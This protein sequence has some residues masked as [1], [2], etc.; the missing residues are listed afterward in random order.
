MA[1]QSIRVDAD[2]K[3]FLIRFAIGEGLAMLSVVSL[4]FAFTD[5]DP[6]VLALGIAGVAIIAGMFLVPK[7]LARS[8][9]QTDSPNFTDGAQ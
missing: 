8:Q 6:M 2:L 5:R 4:W 1:D 7:I 3:R 9:D